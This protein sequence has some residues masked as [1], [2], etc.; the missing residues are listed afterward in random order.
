MRLDHAV[1]LAVSRAFVL[2][3]PFVVCDGVDKLVGALTGYAGPGY[4]V[5]L[6]AASLSEI[7]ARTSAVCVLRGAPISRALGAALRRPGTFIVYTVFA[8]I[9]LWANPF[10][11]DLAGIAVALVVSLAVFASMLALTDSV[12]ENVPP[13]HALAFWLREVC[14]PSRLGVNLVGAL[15]VTLLTYGVW[16]VLYELPLPDWPVVRAV[17]VIPQALVD[18]IAMVFVVLWRDAFLD[19]RR[20]R[21]LEVML[22]VQ[23]RVTTSPQARS[24]GSSTS[25]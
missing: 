20:G 9:E 13:I 7:W 23:D 1:H 4:M 5:W 3:L 18:T 11:S 21:D 2:A 25:Q 8:W 15:A 16:W 22:A 12:S 10:D 14:R 24:P 17:L 19:E 6:I